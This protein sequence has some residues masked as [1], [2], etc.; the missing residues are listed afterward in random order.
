MYTP[1]YYEIHVFD[2]CTALP[3][4]NTRLHDP[5]VKN[6]FSL[7]S[8][9]YVK[10]RQRRWLVERKDSP[11]RWHNIQCTHRSLQHTSSSEHF[12]YPFQRGR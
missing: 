12:L 9:S 11:E 8:I 6:L 7:L 1:V 3:C 10:S 2:D 5:G 4:T